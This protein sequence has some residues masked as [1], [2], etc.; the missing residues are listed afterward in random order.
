VAA[1]LAAPGGRPG[2]RGGRIVTGAGGLV[3]ALLVGLGLVVAGL[4]VRSVLAEWQEARRER[5]RAAE[6]AAERARCAWP[7]SP[8]P[9]PGSRGAE[10]LAL[11][12][13]LR[14]GEALSRW[15]LDWI[16]EER[17]GGVRVGL[18]DAAG[19][20]FQVELRRLAPGGVR[21]L[22]V[23]GELGVYLL[24]V[25]EGAATEEER[26]LGAMVL[27]SWLEGVGAPAP[28][29]LRVHGVPTCASPP[30]RARG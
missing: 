3:R 27:A 7:G 23:A 5:R 25:A 15:T 16:G 19:S 26:G 13:E 11:F 4:L 6:L 10:I 30:A 29:W 17:D 14:P 8:P 1:A 22:A 2:A 28:A 21:P 20:P 24:H 9:A 12:G 18:R